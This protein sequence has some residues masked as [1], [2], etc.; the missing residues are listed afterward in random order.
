MSQVIEN[1]KVKTEVVPLTKQSPTT[2]ALG[3]IVVV[4]LPIILK[5]L[6]LTPIA[7]WSWQKVTFTLWAPWVLTIV[8]SFLGWLVYLVQTRRGRA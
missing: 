6:G 3:Y 2:I 5:A 7:A 8:M 4:L 1:N